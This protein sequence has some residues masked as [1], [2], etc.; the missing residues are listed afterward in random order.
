MPAFE[1]LVARYERPLFN[2]LLRSARN[3]AHAEELLQDVFMRLIERADS[4]SGQSKFS[5]WIYA[6]ARNRCIDHSRRM[7]F[8][9]HASL[10]QPEAAQVASTFA[11]VD[12]DAQRKQLGIE[13]AKAVEEL[14]ADQ[15]EVFLMRQV[16][17]MPFADI[18]EVVGVSVNTAKSR[19]RYALERLQQTLHA[20][21]SHTKEWE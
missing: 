21:E 11:S 19:M 6:I 9:R 13:I 1:E 12:R 20:Y 5:T 14:P 16:Q 7:G 3:R 17:G 10:D 18:A 4:F 2:Y 8:R 15:Q